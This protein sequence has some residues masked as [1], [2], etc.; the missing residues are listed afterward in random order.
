MAVV[1]W[2][3]VGAG[4]IARRRMI[5]EGILTVPEAQLEIVYA[6]NSG[7]DVA[8]QFGVR[9][10][11][12][13]EDVYAAGLDAVYVASPVD[14]HRRQVEQAAAAGLHV[15]CE[16]PLALN[17]DDA[18]SM[19]EACED[20]G[21]LLGVGFMM[22]HH[23]HHQRAAALVQSDAIGVPVYARAQLS[24][25]YPPLAGA[26]RQMPERGGGGAMPDLASHCIDLL[27]YILGATVHS[28]FCHK[29]QRV[30]SYS[31]EDTIV[32]LLEFSTGVVATVD[33]LF[34]TPDAGVRNRLELYGS[35]GSLLAE[36][37]LGQIQTG[38]LELTA[39]GPADKD[40]VD[41]SL[42]NPA[43][44]VAYSLPQGNLYH[45]QV[46][47][48]CDA[49]RHG[50]PPV[51]SGRQGLWIQSVLAGCRQSASEDRRVELDPVDFVAAAIRRGE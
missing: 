14:C 38:T 46:V 20:A 11:D 35:Q 50:C 43:S 23:P 49:I 17:V 28:V 7:H 37:T 29:A 36:N 26:W 8:K 25:W 27:E 2:G 34:S 4:G 5:P 40:V 30:H 44:T 1:R 22:R 42:V 19:V 16:K 31:V 15:L 24:Y 18:R 39:T 10:A 41:P 32:I 51:A 21:V 45:S 12:R 3:V 48:F 47:D 13:E 6:P 9:A 33:C